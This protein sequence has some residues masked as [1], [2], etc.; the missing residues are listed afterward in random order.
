MCL[1]RGLVFIDL[2]NENLIRIGRRLRKIELKTT[3]LLNR[4]R[5]IFFERLYEFFKLNG[6]NFI[7]DQLNVTLRR[8]RGSILGRYRKQHY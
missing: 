3:R 8:L 7:I 5:A 1:Y 4:C 2:V 6:R